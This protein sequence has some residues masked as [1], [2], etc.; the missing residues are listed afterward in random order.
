MSVLKRFLPAWFAGPALDGP[1]VSVH[2]ILAGQHRR[3]ELQ[4]PPRTAPGKT[5]VHLFAGHF[6]SSAAAWHYCFYHTRHRPTALSN[7]LPNAYVDTA[8]I[9]VRFEDYQRR[10][11]E[12]LP[13]S[14]VAALLREMDNRNTLVIIAEPAFS[15][16]PY[17]L[18]DTPYL[19]YLG[20]LVIKN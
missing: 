5:R 18:N 15:G 6:E 13:P 1:A 20:P 8:H 11:A 7:D 19:G 9:E 4:S 16:L 10:L 12:I 3:V 2:D 14:P 17:A